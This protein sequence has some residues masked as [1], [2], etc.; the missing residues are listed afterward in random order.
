M[1]YAFV[2][3]MFFLVIMDIY[4]AGSKKSPLLGFI[5][6]VV[7]ICVVA[8]GQGMS[9]DIPFFPLPNVLL[10]L[11]AIVTMLSAGLSIKG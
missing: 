10:G 9:A 8:A 5:F 2:I 7:S 6:A 3:V 1:E 4:L 11:T